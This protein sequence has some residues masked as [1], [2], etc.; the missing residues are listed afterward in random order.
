MTTC[1]KC[2]STDVVSAGLCMT[3]FDTTCAY[4]QGEKSFHAQLCK[5]CWKSDVWLQES[6]ENFK[7][8]K[9]QSLLTKTLGLA[10]IKQ[11]YVNVLLRHE[12]DYVQAFTA[13][14]AN[15]NVNY[16]IFEM[17]GDSVANAFLTWYFFR[18]FP[19]LNCPE[20]VKVLARL[21]I[22]YASKRSFAS[23]AD[24]LGF[25]PF[26]NASK[27]AKDADPS[28]LL[29]DVFEA[30]VGV[31]TMILDNE[32]S[33]GVG[34]GIVYDLLAAIFDDLPISLEYEDLYDAKTRLK[35]LFD[36]NQ[37]TLGKLEYNDEATSTTIY[38]VP[39]SGPKIKLGYGTGRTKAER[40]QM[41]AK[42]GLDLM[43]REG[44]TRKNPY[45]LICE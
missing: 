45:A 29:E 11:H 2:E 38:R 37:S 23:I 44:Y 40:Q 24:K 20:G 5:S 18:R 14:S 36:A 26:I 3:C 33:V 41:A 35:E 17:L 27:E 42:I 15:A 7:P 19:Q 9:M 34:F 16:E 1:L 13:K 12:D 6:Q 43:E 30:F 8:S 31:T 39:I 21:K 28:S 22:N 4:C 10:K 32:Y 25:W